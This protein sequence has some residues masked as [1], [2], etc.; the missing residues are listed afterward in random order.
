M[1]EEFRSAAEMLVAG[2][3]LPPAS[4]AKGP[5][6]PTACPPGT[7]CAISGRAITEGYPVA[8][9]VASETSEMMDCFRGGMD[10]WVSEPVARAF[11]SANPRAGNPCAKSTVVLSAG[12]GG[13]RCWQPL[14]ARESAEKQG[15]ACWSDLVREVW[16]GERGAPCLMILTTNTKRRLWPWARSGALGDRTPVLYFDN[17]TDGFQVLRIGWP[18]L[19][20]CLDLVEEAYGAGFTK[21]QIRGSLYAGSAAIEALGEGG[22]AR[23]RDWER[24]L[25]GW[26]STPEFRMAA[27]IAQKPRETAV[28][29]T[30]S[31]ATEQDGAG[32]GPEEAAS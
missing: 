10:G 14:I 1:V 31:G 12:D 22:L 28:S 16:P 11:K 6:P 3:S 4:D 27:L 20:D 15:R 17:D 5:V 25:D 24:A 23:T 21:A 7:R 8:S 18:R 19:I 32:R 26:R 2:L 30:T 9:I 29:E 13:V